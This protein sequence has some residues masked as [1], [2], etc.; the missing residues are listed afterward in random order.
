MIRRSQPF[1]LQMTP[2]TKNASAVKCVTLTTSYGNPHAK[3]LYY[4]ATMQNFPKTRRCTLPLFNRQPPPRRSKTNATADLSA[5]N[6]TSAILGQHK[7]RPDRDDS[8]RTRSVTTPSV[9]LSHDAENAFITGN[10]T[11]PF[12]IVWMYNTNATADV[13]P[14]NGISAILGQHK[15][16]AQIAIIMNGRGLSPPPPF[17]LRSLYT[18]TSVPLDMAPGAYD[19]PLT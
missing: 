6:G 15:A 4:M 14:Y 10:K 18:H 13:S 17:G 16:C 7:A 2:E 8:E 9:P 11:P 12:I 1:L 3:A 5:C 19:A